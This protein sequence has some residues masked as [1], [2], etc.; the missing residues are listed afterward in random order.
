MNLNQSPIITER[1]IE[2]LQ[3][4]CWEFIH[5]KCDRMKRQSLYSRDVQDLVYEIRQK[6][7]ELNPKY[8][9]RSVIGFVE[10]FY[11]DFFY[12]LVNIV[13]EGESNTHC[14]NKLS[15]K[16][17]EKISSVVFPNCKKGTKVL[18]PVRYLVAAVYYEP[19]H[20][21][22][23]EK[24]K[25]KSMTITNKEHKFNVDRRGERYLERQRN[26]SHDREQKLEEGL[27]FKNASLDTTVSNL[28]F[29]SERNFVLQQVRKTW[30]DLV[31][32]R[33][34]STAQL[35]E[36]DMKYLST[37]IANLASAD[38][39][40]ADC[41]IGIMGG[42]SEGKSTFLNA[43]LGCKDLLASGCGAV[44]TVCTEIRYCPSRDY[45]VRLC[46][47]PAKEIYEDVKYY[48]SQEDGEVDETDD[49]HIDIV[50][51]RL[52]GLFDLEKSDLPAETLVPLSPKAIKFI[53]HKPIEYRHTDIREIQKWLKQNLEANKDV[54]QYC[55]DII[56]I[57]GPFEHIPPG[58]TLIDT[59]GLGDGEKVNS[60]R[61]LEYMESFDCIW[62]ANHHGKAMSNK[63][64]AEFL[65]SIKTMIDKEIHIIATQADTES[66]RTQE[67]SDL[68]IKN[69]QKHY[70]RDFLWKKYANDDK[71]L[72]S[73]LINETFVLNK[74]ANAF[75][76]EKEL[77]DQRVAAINVI[78]TS[79]DIPTNSL[80][81]GKDDWM[82]M[83]R[84]KCQ[85]KVEEFSKQH[86]FLMTVYESI[87]S[88]S[89][90]V[91]SG[92]A[93]TTGLIRNDFFSTDEH[94]TSST[95][96]NHSSNYNNMSATEVTDWWKEILHDSFHQP[97]LQTMLSESSIIT[98]NQNI[99]NS[100]TSYRL[101]SNTIKATMNL[102]NRGV[103]KSRSYVQ[104]MMVGKRLLDINQDIASEW[105]NRAA[106]HWHTALQ[107]LETF[108]EYVNG[109]YPQVQGWMTNFIPQTKEHGNTIFN[110]R[111]LKD[112]IRGVLHEW[113]VYHDEPKK[114]VNIP[115]SPDEV[116]GKKRRKS[117]KNSV[118]APP[119][120]G[121]PT[122]AI[123]TRLFR[124]CI[125]PK[126]D[127]FLTSLEQMMNALL[128]EIPKDTLFTTT[129]ESIRQI[130]VHHLS[131]TTTAQQQL[132]SS[133]SSAECFPPIAF[134]CA[135][136]CELLRNPVSLRG[137]ACRY[138]TIDLSVM[139][140]TCFSMMNNQEEV[141]EEVVE[142]D[143]DMDSVQFSKMSLISCPLCTQPTNI[144]RRHDLTIAINSWQQMH[145]HVVVA[146]TL[147]GKVQQWWKSINCSAASSPDTPPTSSPQKRQRIE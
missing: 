58:V 1:D 56:Y 36:A 42:V 139:P 17:I 127:T 47:V 22:R 128:E 20:N 66:N 74:M 6:L 118:H 146:N 11:A 105:V 15:W 77:L 100:F 76:E 37:L 130:V 41:R 50:I 34:D 82:K 64:N 132:P 140:K 44:T 136:T 53:N 142:K 13:Q 32:L 10:A 106:S 21:L 52:S 46:F 94:S 65:C 126:V 7:F 112:E 147:A 29:Y 16:Q 131:P 54:Y 87:Q 43:L 124:E 81:A 35:N 63:E 123:L 134:T 24:N 49:A 104:N 111:S 145:N 55:L 107:E 67:T 28:E 78:F 19:R 141:D 38:T 91:A 143:E 88:V 133:P 3:T 138:V 97:L 69:M 80:Q 2:N 101:A 92:V 73:Q 26:L 117:A 96:S 75:K 30:K 39:C 33:K 86:Q 90:S 121:L 95:G 85:S 57:E 4:I 45:A 72:R 102:K 12:C 122:A 93:T 31:L 116:A 125:Q 137:C 98:M 109:A 8:F 14:W 115:S 83:I 119:L 5:Q 108:L 103:F 135:S 25:L 110:V 68:Y 59:P 23:D 61:T 70:Y 79:V 84:L 129:N 60:S 27:L 99:L 114:E 120:Y 113:K 89:S 9:S 62:Y 18:K 71:L 51:N 48:N 40:L 144:H